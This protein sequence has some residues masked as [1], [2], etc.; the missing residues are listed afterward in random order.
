MGGLPWLCVTNQCQGVG[1]LMDKDAEWLDTGP[2]IQLIRSVHVPPI[3]DLIL[4]Q[5]SLMTDGQLLQNTF[6]G[7]SMGRHIQVIL[8]WSLLLSL[9][10]IA[11]IGTTTNGASKKYGLSRARGTTK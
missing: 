3:L 2:L 8:E 9:P 5:S 7:E 6:E 10:H 4:G 1:D 11:I